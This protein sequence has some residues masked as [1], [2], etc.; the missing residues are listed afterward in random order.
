[1]QTVHLFQRLGE[2]EVLDVRGLA[3]SMIDFVY[4]FA[5]ISYQN[6]PN[7]LQIRMFM[8]CFV[9]YRCCC[10][11][12]EKFEKKYDDSGVWEKSSP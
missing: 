11:F 6:L 1:M 3:L 2:R 4:L 9:L 12:T 5:Y 8:F 7:T 10:C